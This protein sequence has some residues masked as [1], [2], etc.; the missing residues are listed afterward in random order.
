MV[1]KLFNDKTASLA[2]KSVAG[3][4]VKN[5]NKELHG[6]IIRKFEKRTNSHLL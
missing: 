1:L 4:A 6:P 3:G 5:E 2:D